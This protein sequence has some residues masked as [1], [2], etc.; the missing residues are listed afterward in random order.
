[1][2]QPIPDDWNG[3]D[4]VCV[5][6]DWPDSQQYI[7]LLFGFL[8]ELTR[9]RYWDKKTG[10]IKDAQNIGIQIAT[11][12][13]PLRLCETC[14]DG[15]DSEPQFYGM[16]SE[17]IGE[18]EE[19][20]SIQ[21]L[22]VEDGKLYM[23]FSPCCKVPVEG[24]FS[25]IIDDVPPDTNTDPADPQTWACN[26]AYWI[27]DTLI[28]V[29]SDVV[30]VIAGLGAVYNMYSPAHKVLAQFGSTWQ[31]TQ[32]VCAAYVA[33]AT[34]IETMLTDPDL[35]AWLACGWHTNFAATDNM[36]SS[37]QYAMVTT[38]PAK[39]TSG[40]QMFLR[41]MV[42]AMSLSTLQWWARLFYDRI[43]D[44]SCPE[45]TGDSIPTTSGWYWGAVQPEM[46]FNVPYNQGGAFP[47]NEWGYPFNKIV[48]PHDVYGCQWKVSIV[49]GTV[50]AYKRSN[51]AQSW[52]G[53][54]DHY[55]SGSN[56]DSL[57][58]GTL[59]VQVN[60]DQFDELYPAGGATRIVP[61]SGDGSSTVN[62]PVLAQGGIALMTCSLHESA[63]A[64]TSVVRMSDFRWL[65]NTGS[66][67][68]S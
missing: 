2:Q 7:A 52:M 42:Q 46:V 57:T 56:S 1:M 29:A 25:S 60:T 11:R 37:E 15:N 35:A 53:S 48:V 67:S 32:L 5:Q 58:P 34:E 24:E 17:D 4:W 63:P 65:H 21:W 31:T 61:L 54:H 20:S 18:D 12:N 30:D 26:K 68:H 28:D 66:P 13:L 33:D 40:Q 10:S 47:D 9:G 62:S 45:D 64:V 23:H 41:R 36:N 59:Y 49:S 22:T 16:A 44:C 55:F 39:Y 50:S 27:A 8:T 14:Q 43:A 51:D 6:I 3:Q 38:L 19:M